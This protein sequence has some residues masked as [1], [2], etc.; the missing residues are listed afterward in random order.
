MKIVLN[1]SVEVIEL[2]PQIVVYRNV[3]KDI[4]KTYEVLKE[5]SKNLEDR[6]LSPWTQWSHF[7]EYLNPVMK[8]FDKTKR[9]GVEAIESMETNTVIEKNQKEFLIELIEGFYN[10]TEHYLSKYGEEFGFNLKEKARSEEEELFN[11]WEMYGPSICKYHKDILN[12]M[13]MTYHSDY[14]REPIE[15]PGYKFALT[16]NA[17]FNDDYEG[18]EIDF[19]IGKELYKYKPQAGDWLLFPSG[20]PDFLTKDGNVYLHGVLPSKKAEKYFSRMYWRKY[21]EGSPEWFEKQKE[22]GKEEWES[23]QSKIMEEYAIA[24]PQRAYIEDGVR[25]I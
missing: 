3:F 22:F 19:C 14:M 7:G 25:V 1:S 2:Y 11:R 4:E 12:A 16:A 6:F 15:S 23:M 20:H 18:G 13:S 9:F 5:S 10:V 21:S 17:Y 8:N 24:N